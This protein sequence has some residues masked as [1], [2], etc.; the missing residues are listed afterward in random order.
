MIS[1]IILKLVRSCYHL[2]TF[3]SPVNKAYLLRKNSI[4]NKSVEDELIKMILNFLDFLAPLENFH[5]VLLWFIRTFLYS[6]L[7]LPFW[8]TQTKTHTWFYK[9]LCS[10]YKLS[11]YIHCI[12]LARLYKHLLININSARSRA[13]LKF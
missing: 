3:L 12:L 4:I 5:A 6:K 9:I 8:I 11:N 2:S 10:L 7:R 1:R 13:S